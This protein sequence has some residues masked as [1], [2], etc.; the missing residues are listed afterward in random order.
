MKSEKRGMKRRAA[1]LALLLAAAVGAAPLR[2][3][4]DSAGGAEAAAGS[5]AQIVDDG[6][7]DGFTDLADD[8]TGTDAAVDG[9]DA[10]AGS[11]SGASSGNASSAGAAAADPA[12]AILVRNANLTVARIA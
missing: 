7:T 8:E 3:P 12:P 1:L 2:I 10:D 11:G 9:T 5:E 4:A 6:G